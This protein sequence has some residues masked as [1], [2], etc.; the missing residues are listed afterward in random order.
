MTDTMAPET[1][2]GTTVSTLTV[3]LGA[4]TYEIV[5][6]ED[7]LSTAGSR[8][9]VVMPQPRAFIV[10]DSNVAPLYLERLERSLEAAG[11]E[12]TSIILPAGESTKNLDHLRQLTNWMLDHR[13]ERSSTVIAFGGGVI[14]DIAG[15]A[16]SV[17]LRGINVVQIPTSLLAQVDSSVGGKTGINSPHGKNLIGTFHQPSLVLA[18][19]GVLE[20]LPPR[21]LLAGYAETVKYGLI[22]DAAFFEWMETN[23]ERL[24]GG[25]RAARREAV[26]HACAA[27]AAVVAEDEREFGRRALL[28]LGHTFGHAFEAETG[29]GGRLLH[30]EAVSIGIVMA[31]DVS[32]AMKLCPPGDADRAR[33]H[34]QARGLPV[35]LSGIADPSWTAEKLL[36]HITQDKKVAGKRPTFILSRGIGQAFTTQD[37]DP[38]FLR[39]FLENTLKG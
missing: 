16:A 6:G 12:H 22:D 15:F 33:R 13:V 35:D 21:E 1:P 28:N 20:S 37:V 23:G 8:L 36:A 3:D 34:L 19:V 38:D 31:M 10:T 26:I 2:A 14:G 32:A 9:R 5:V 39:R 27:K 24:I 4:R 18:D 30:G 29:Y 17:V 7:L 25:D 11:I